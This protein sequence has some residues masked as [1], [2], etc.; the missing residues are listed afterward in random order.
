[1]RTLILENPRQSTE[2]LGG[3]VPLPVACRATLSV[4]SRPGTRAQNAGTALARE[5][6]I[7][8][9]GQDP[10]K[11]APNHSPRFFV[12]EAALVPV[13]RAMASLA[14]SQLGQW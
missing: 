9:R 10:T 13:I 3:F 6:D 8:P 7:V 12:D 14:S 4:L 11:V 5:I 2:Y 1:M